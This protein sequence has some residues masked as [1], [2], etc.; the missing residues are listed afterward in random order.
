MFL[1][2]NRYVKVQ[3]VGK[4]EECPKSRPKKLKMGS[5]EKSR[6]TLKTNG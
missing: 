1:K 5:I 6:A 4:V 2:A 3:S